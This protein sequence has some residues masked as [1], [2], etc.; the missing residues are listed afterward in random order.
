VQ[1]TGTFDLVGSSMTLPLSLVLH[2]LGS[3]GDTADFGDTSQVS[4]ILPG[5]VT[6]TSTSG[7][8]LTGGATATPEPSSLAFL[9]LAAGA[10]VFIRFRQNKQK[11]Q[12]TK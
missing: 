7:A 5:N 12:T 6:F 9:G 10:L 11:L 2:T 3:N 1:F 8:F 4:L